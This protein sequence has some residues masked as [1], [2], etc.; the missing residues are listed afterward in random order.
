MKRALSGSLLLAVIEIA[1]LQAQPPTPTPTRLPAEARPVDGNAPI[2]LDSTPGPRATPSQIL[3][4][5]SAQ[6]DSLERAIEETY[7][8]LVQ[9]K[10]GE[11]Q[12]LQEQMAALNDQ[13]R[14]LRAAREKLK[15]MAA[16]IQS[17][18]EQQAAASLSKKIDLLEVK[19]QRIKASLMMRTPAPT[20]KKKTPSP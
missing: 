2:R 17:Y 3:A 18:Q 14:Q 13:I 20:P 15:K 10:R 6:Y 5:V 16:A 8:K 1:A 9:E 11:I 12:Q 19:A 4:D 7:Q